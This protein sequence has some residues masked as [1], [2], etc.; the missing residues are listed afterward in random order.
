MSEN[1]SLHQCF[2]DWLMMEIWVGNHVSSDFQGQCCAFFQFPVLLLRIFKIL[3]LNC[4]VALE[5]L[6]S[7]VLSSFWSLS[8]VFWCV[9]IFTHCLGCFTVKTHILQLWKSSSDYFFNDFLPVLCL[10]SSNTPSCWASLP[11]LTF[12]TLKLF[13]WLYRVFSLFLSLT[14]LQS[15]LFIAFLISKSS[16][17]FSKYFL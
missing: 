5:T 3:T 12:S 2:M 11:D 16:L 17:L 8:V 9:S 10:C 14:L 1:L 13:F 15:L 7:V 4:C 6:R